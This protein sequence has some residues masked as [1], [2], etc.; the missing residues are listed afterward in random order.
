MRRIRQV[1]LC[2]A[3]AMLAAC[4]GDD[5]TLPGGSEA[6][7]PPGSDA[8][9]TASVVTEPDETEPTITAPPPGVTVAAS[10]TAAPTTAP[11]TTVAPTV[12]TIA[13]R[14]NRT[15]DGSFEIFT[16]R[17]DG[18]GLTQLTDGP[19]AALA[20][21]WSPD[22]TRIAFTAARGGEADDIYVMD[23]DGSDVVR[24]TDH[25]A[26]DRDP[27]WSPDGTQIVFVSER[28]GN[29]EI[30][31]MD[32]DGSDQVR[33]T[34]QP[35]YDDHPDWG[36]DGRIVFASRRDGNWELYLMSPDG[37][38]L[39]NIT[40]VPEGQDNYPVWSPDGGWIAFQSNRERAPTTEQ[41]DLWVVRPDGT[42]V[43]FVVP[44]LL[45]GCLLGE[46]ATWSPDSTRL[47]FATGCNTTVAGAIELSISTLDS[48]EQ[49]AVLPG[50]AF[51]PPRSNDLFTRDQDPDWTHR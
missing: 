39:T 9:T 3:L 26:V 41:H 49:R 21:D 36:P 32:A 13:F 1:A 30:Y 14:S 23:A 38:G 2:A 22:G 29:P 31:V 48:S 24:L 50:E 46:S 18:S 47:A 7:G 40:N 37:T 4:G 25:P 16:V 51:V 33:L 28:D 35:E 45:G 15:A 42:E 5:G 10:T 44:G 43:H 20:P 11:P 27:S 34:E 8:T 17:A 12:D 6:T 19:G